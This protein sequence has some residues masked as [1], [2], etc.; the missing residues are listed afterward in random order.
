M[1]ADK[2]ITLFVDLKGYNLFFH[3]LVIPEFPYEVI[4]GSD[5]FQKWKI[6]LDPVAVEFIS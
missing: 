4:A 2:T 6:R 5:F 1:K 3:F